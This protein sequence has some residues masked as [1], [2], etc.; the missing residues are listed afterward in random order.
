MA[1]EK[2]KQRVGR[3]FAPQETKDSIFRFNLG[4]TGRSRSCVCEPGG[5]V[6]LVPCLRR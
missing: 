5:N 1:F 2:A 6:T 3:C 4:Y